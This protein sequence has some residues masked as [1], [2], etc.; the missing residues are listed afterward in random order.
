ML[1]DNFNILRHTQICDV[2]ESR[3]IFNFKFAC[4]TNKHIR[5]G[6]EPTFS[7][8]VKGDGIGITLIYHMQVAFVPNSVA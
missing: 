3:L 1:T 4:I 5:Q 6:C 2:T 7:H 8:E